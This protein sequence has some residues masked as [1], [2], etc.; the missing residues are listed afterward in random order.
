SMSVIAALP[1]VGA[2]GEPVDFA[3]TIASHGVAELP[4][5][6]L[7]LAA[8]TLETTLAVPGGARSVRVTHGDGSMRVELEAG[9]V[10]QTQVTALNAA[11]RHIFRLDEDLSAFYE[12]VRRAPQ[13][14]R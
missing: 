6:R 4:P 2:G 1:L 8:R 13:H 10:G 7:D 3:R 11:L 5:N 9:R 12:V 14:D